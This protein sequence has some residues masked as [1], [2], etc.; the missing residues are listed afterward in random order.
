M[1][2]W[3]F[4]ERIL[5]GAP[6]QVFGEGRP[7]RDFTFVEDC[8]DNIVRLLDRALATD[9]D[10]V[11]HQVV[12]VGSDNPVPVATLIDIVE[13]HTGRRA[14]RVL[15]PLP[16]GDVGLDGRGSDAARGI[17]RRPAASPLDIGIE[18]FDFL[19]SAASAACRCSLAVA[20]QRRESDREAGRGE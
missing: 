4:T 7:R 18:R 3:L 10:Q 15:R 1:A 19:V 2:P 17:G 20:R 12:N 8:A 6:I 16:P 9:P 14:E 5:R 11:E 13:R